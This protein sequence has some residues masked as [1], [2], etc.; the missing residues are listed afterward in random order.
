MISL[1]WSTKLWTGL[2]S[3]KFLIRKRLGL[4]YLLKFFL[5]PFTLFDSF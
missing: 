3:L 2:V 1:A 5:S 4:F